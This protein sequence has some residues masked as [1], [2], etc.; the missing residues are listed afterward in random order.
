MTGMGASDW[1]YITAED[2]NKPSSNTPVAF[3]LANFK[4]LSIRQASTFPNDFKKL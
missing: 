2:S 4:V 1:Q 3:V